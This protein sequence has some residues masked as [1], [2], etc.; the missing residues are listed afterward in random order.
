MKVQ[1]YHGTTVKRAQK[2]IADKKIKVTDSKIIRHEGTTQ[3]YVYVTKRL[4]DALDFSTR[5]M[6]GEDTLTFVVFQILI[7]ENDLQIDPDEGNWNSTL[8]DGGAKECYRIKRDL[9]FGKDAVSVFC[10]KMP[11]NDVAGNY[12][13]DIQ[14]GTRIIKESEWKKL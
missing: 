5:P 9:L 7:D 2:I 11:S 10:K 4:C 12:M 1:V 3:G 14:D 8:S 6:I 13:Q